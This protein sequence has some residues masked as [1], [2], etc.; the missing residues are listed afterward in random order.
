MPPEVLTCSKVRRGTPPPIFLV[1]PHPAAS[2]LSS[3]QD[4]VSLLLHGPLF[5]KFSD[6]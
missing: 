1:L 6:T 3:T 2:K 4:L 5:V